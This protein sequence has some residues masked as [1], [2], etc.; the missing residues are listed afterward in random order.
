MP[1]MVPGS[2]H[3]ARHRC[4]STQAS[5]LS[6]GSLPR[7]VAPLSGFLNRMNSL[8]YDTG[9]LEVFKANVAFIHSHNAAHPSHKVRPHAQQ[10]L[11]QQLYS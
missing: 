4:A 11:P 8:Q 7:L 2:A 6:S 9:K 10:R 3:M 5:D 1:H